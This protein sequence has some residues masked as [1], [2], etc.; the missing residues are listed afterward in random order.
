[1]I[2]LSGC[3]AHDRFALKLNAQLD[4]CAMKRMAET[5]FNSQQGY[6]QA[7]YECHQIVNIQK[8]HALHLERVDVSAQ[9]KKDAFEEYTG[10]WEFAKD[11][12]LDKYYPDLRLIEQKNG[13]NLTKSE[14]YENKVTL[15]FRKLALPNKLSDLN[16]QKLI[17][18]RDMREKYYPDYLEPEQEVIRANVLN[19]QQAK[20]I[21]DPSL[22]RE[23]EPRLLPVSPYLMHYNNLRMAQEIVSDLIYQHRED[24]FFTKLKVISTIL[25]TESQKKDPYTYRY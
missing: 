13:H 22:L 12:V 11:L 5:K 15:E 2:G 23:W 19:E 21:T 20:T 7:H 10:C 1:M 6:L 4:A 16:K 14:E 8:G 17:M 18:V 25:V 24:E 9:N 3:T